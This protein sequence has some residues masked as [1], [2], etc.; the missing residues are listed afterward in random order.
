MWYAM[1]D[2]G[3]TYQQ[4]NHYYQKHNLLAKKVIIPHQYSMLSCYLTDQFIH[5]HGLHTAFYGITYPH[6]RKSG[7]KQ[8]P[9]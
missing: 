9:F 1:R 2:Y 6:N 3:K 5:H 4:T 8:N 7:Q